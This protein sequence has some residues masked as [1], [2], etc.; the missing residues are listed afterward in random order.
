MGTFSGKA[1]ACGRSDVV[2]TASEWGIWL[3]IGEMLQIK[4]T[5][6]SF[7]VSKKSAPAFSRKRIWLKFEWRKP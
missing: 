1:R 2:T 4:H 6:N 7:P 5:N 3:K